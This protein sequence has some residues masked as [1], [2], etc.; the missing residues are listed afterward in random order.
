M[1]AISHDSFKPMEPIPNSPAENQAL[2]QARAKQARDHLAA[3]AAAVEQAQ[4]QLSKQAQT[5]R[6]LGGSSIP[7]MP[8]GLD[9]RLSRGMQTELQSRE[10]SELRAEKAKSLPDLR[11]AVKKAEKKAANLQGHLQ[12]A[13]DQLAKLDARKGTDADEPQRRLEI[14]TLRDV[15]LKDTTEAYQLVGAANSSVRQLEAELDDPLCQFCRA[16]VEWI[17]AAMELL[18]PMLAEAREIL[19][20]KAEEVESGKPHKDAKPRKGPEM[21][22]AMKP[23]E[24]GNIVNLGT[25]RQTPR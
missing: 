6:S 2:A 11:D 3:H 19:R 18:P 20:W 7:A 10:A 12:K 4:E 14:M 23:M 1:T 9:L 25:A 8:A 21:G 13:I 17:E 24:D 15:L 22:G 16:R 5:A